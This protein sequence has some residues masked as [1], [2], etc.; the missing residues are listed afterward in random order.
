LLSGK[1]HYIASD[2]TDEYTGGRVTTEAYKDY[3]GYYDESY[4]VEDRKLYD[5][6]G[7]LRH[8]IYREY[9][10]D[11]C[12][13]E[14][15]TYY[16]CHGTRIYYSEEWYDDFDG[17]SYE[18]Y[19][20]FYKEG[21][22]TAGYY[23]YDDYYD[24]YREYYD[25]ASGEWVEKWSPD[26]NKPSDFHPDFADCPDECRYWYHDFFGGFS[27]IREDDG[28]DGFYLYG[29]L[30]AY[31]YNISK[32][33]GITADAGLDFRKEN[34]TKITKLILLAGATYWAKEPCFSNPWSFSL[35]ALAGISNI[36]Y[37]YS[38]QFGSFKSSDS[39]F[40]LGL[41]G[42]I[43][44]YFTPKWGLGLRLDALPTFARNNTSFNLRAGLGLIHR[45]E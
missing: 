42:S 40:T 44:Y 13:Y 11:D 9:Y 21:R 43:G 41:G 4:N 33:V 19:E 24:G 15:E 1:D 22:R 2:K 37:N 27:I 28:S 3:D 45:V 6:N 38:S 20:S 7:T 23:Y 31:T 30:A 14:E 35:H 25:P 26:L 18:L 10:S 5:K 32:R 29:L 8:E 34:D 17:Y 16:D 39:Y 12:V 36:H